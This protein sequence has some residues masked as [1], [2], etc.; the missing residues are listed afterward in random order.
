MSITVKALLL[1]P[2]S[3]NH[4]ITKE[5]NRVFIFAGECHPA[6]F[7]VFKLRCSKTLWTFDGCKFTEKQKWNIVMQSIRHIHVADLV[8]GGGRQGNLTQPYALTKN[9]ITWIK[10]PIF[11]RPYN[12]CC[13]TFF[14]V[15]VWKH[16]FIS[17][18]WSIFYNGQ[19]GHAVSEKKVSSLIIQQDREYIHQFMPYI[20][21]LAGFIRTWF[22]KRT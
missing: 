7:H 8:G 16:H 3:K 19:S 2:F 11:L 14:E 18:R 21:K 20:I 22:L 17:A 13:W 12:I 5:K 1:K 9:I 4:S 6:T 15:S 10:G